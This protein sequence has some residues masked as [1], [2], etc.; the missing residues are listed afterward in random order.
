M[1]Y[2]YR[3]AAPRHPVRPLLR[4]LR[5]ARSIRAPERRTRLAVGPALRLR[6]AHPARHGLPLRALRGPGARPGGARARC[7]T[8]RT[9][10]STA[11]PA[12]CATP[13]RG[14]TG[15]SRS[16]H[17]VAVDAQRLPRGGPAPRR[18]G[19]HRP[20]GRRG[21]G[22]LRSRRRDHAR[23]GAGVRHR[24]DRQPDPGLRPLRR[25]SP[26][27]R[28]STTSIDQLGRIPATG[29]RRR[30]RAPGQ[31]RATR[32]TR[33][34]PAAPARTPG[35]LRGRG[36]D[37]ARSCP[38]RSSCRASSSSTWSSRATGPSL[39]AAVLAE[40][41]R[42]LDLLLRL[43]A[44]RPMPRG[45]NA[46]ARI[47][48]SATRGARCRCS[49]RSTRRSASA[50]SAPRTSGAEASPLLRGHR[51]RLRHRA[52]S[53]ASPG[54]ACRPSCSPSSTR[55]SPSGARADRDHAEDLDRMAPV[56]RRVDAE[57]PL[58]DA[59]QVMV[60]LAAASQEALDARRL[61]APLRRTPAAPRARACSAASATPTPSSAARSK[62]TCGPRR[63]YRPDA[64]FAEVV[65]LPAGADRQHPGA[66]GAARV[67]DPLP[68]PLRRAARAA[69]PGHRPARS[70][71]SGTASC[72]A[73]RGSAGR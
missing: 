10:A 11:P 42:G 40:I 44:D 31:M 64:I 30:R 13:R 24:A 17:L 14:W 26:A 59:F 54:A 12:G 45:S 2:F 4:L 70:R 9:P 15:R 72:C 63:R 16:H 48:T 36:R 37:A 57:L 58:P 18:R 50:S 65:H 27:R 6:A 55:R 28:R 52:P 32:W 21:P 66:A 3:M 46:S 49:R 5:W 62:S 47:S 56:D 8:A 33:S 73:R 34:T 19:R 69:D 20:R 53:R 51:A 71:C 29:R 68:R 38:P 43:A 60:T 7:S 67:R 41:V 1:R 61:P 35:A 23:R 25:R 39:G 22:G